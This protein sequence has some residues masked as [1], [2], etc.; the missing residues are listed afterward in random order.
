MRAGEAGAE[1]SV[2][3]FNCWYQLSKINDGIPK[4]VAAI[5]EAGADVVGLQE[6]SVETADKLA[7]TLGFHRVKS[8]AGGAQIISRFPIL[9]TFG[10]TGMDPTRAVAARIRTGGGREFIFYNIHLDAGHYGPYAGRPA[11]ATADQVMA[12]EAK[13][14]RAAQMSGILGSM[15]GHLAQCDA[16]PVILTGDFNS[17]SQLDWV[18]KTSA[19]HFGIA[20]VPWPATV[21]PFQAGLV[22]SF[23]LLHPDPAAFPGTTWSTIHK[24]GEPQDRIDYIFHKGTAIRPI[25]SRTFATSVAR[26]IGVWGS[27]ISPVVDNAW[28]SDH[29][30]VI[31]VYR[32]AN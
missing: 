18:E 8:G 1:L 16:T 15:A 29:A 3:S 10:V 7:E 21:L 2:M 12:E 24:E 4:A 28:P 9:D 17:P 26:T 25:S 5:K 23:R 19:S 11:G 31:T 13:S 22:D 14:P 20:A 27:D 30:A 32:F 6:C